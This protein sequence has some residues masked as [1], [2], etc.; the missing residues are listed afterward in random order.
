MIHILDGRLGGDLRP[1][2]LVEG[3]AVYLTGGHFKKVDVLTQAAG[4]LQIQDAPYAQADL[5]WLIPVRQL[6]DQFYTSQHEI[7]YME[8]A[9][10]IKFMV[11]KYG[12]DA[13]NKF[14]RDIHRQDSNSQADAIG[15]A[16]QVHFGI[17]LDQ[18]QE[19][20]ISALRSQEVTSLQVEDMRET[21]RYFDTMR[22][23]QEL[24]DPSAY[25]VHAWLLD[26]AQMREKGIVADYNRHPEAPYNLA[27]ETLL[28]EADDSLLN[29]QYQETSGVIQSAN[30]VL[31]AIQHRLSDPFKVDPQALAYYNIVLTLLAAGYH[32]QQ[33][34]LNGDTALAKVTI[35]PEEGLLQ[36]A[37]QQV[38]GIWRMLQ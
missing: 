36:V 31:D 30:A 12:W 23:Y 33:I 19:Q 35:P 27:L 3:L 29:D 11:Q 16:L 37:L 6:A 8:A 17:D 4:L 9:G 32:P 7:G 20:F 38:G 25:F 15:T 2:M 13:F 14:Y 24:L 18:L 28:V 21:V 1:T 34:Q 10:L 26:S 22:R 5:G